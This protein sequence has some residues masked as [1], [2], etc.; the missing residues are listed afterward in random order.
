MNFEELEKSV[1]FKYWRTLPRK[2]ISNI[3]ISRFMKKP[4]LEKYII[5]MTPILNN[6]ILKQDLINLG[7]N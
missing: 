4:Y 5:D 1:I 6:D 2:S 3:L 7:K